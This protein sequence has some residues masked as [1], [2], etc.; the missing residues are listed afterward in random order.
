MLAV[1]ELGR[2]VAG[3]RIGLLS[4]VI[5]G[6]TLLFQRYY[7]QS[8]TDVHLTLWVAICN[9]C[10]AHILFNKRWWSALVPGAIALGIAFLCKGPVA[11]VQTVVPVLAFGLVRQFVVPTESVGDS[12]SAAKAS[13]KFSG[14]IVFLLIFVCIASPWFV[15]VYQTVPGVWTGGLVR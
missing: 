10:L 7:R 4:C 3:A 2:V 8:T 13:G 5:V 11:L 12:T 14:V 15:Y 1:F 9:V 6:T